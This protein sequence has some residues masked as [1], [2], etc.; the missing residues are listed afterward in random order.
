M[1]PEVVREYNYINSQLHEPVYNITFV[2]HRD[3]SSPGRTGYVNLAV[4]REYLSAGRNGSTSTT[5]CV[6]MSRHIASLVVDYSAS[7]RLVVDYFAYAARPG[8]LARRAARHVASR[9]TRRRLLRVAQSHRRLLRVPRL[10]LAATLAL[11]QPRR[12][13]RLLALRQ[14]WLYFEYAARRHDIVFRSH[15]VDHSS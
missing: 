15:R 14:H 10:R 2:V 4:R 3:Y 12:G 11:L 7:R 1:H 8:A 5:S 9:A 13:A 6:R